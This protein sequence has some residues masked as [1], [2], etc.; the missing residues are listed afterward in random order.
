METPVEK[1]ER[2]KKGEQQNT[3]HGRVSVSLPLTTQ[4]CSLADANATAQTMGTR[5]NVLPIGRNVVYIAGTT[6]H[7]LKV[8]VSGA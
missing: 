2:I 1:P 8:L 3:P 4:H 6:R 7:V 5:N